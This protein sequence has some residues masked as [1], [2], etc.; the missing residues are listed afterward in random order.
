MEADMGKWNR[1]LAAAVPPG[2]AAPPGAGATLAPKREVQRLGRGES[3]MMVVEPAL[4][5]IAP[6]NTVR[7][8]A[9]HPGHSAGS[10]PAMLPVGTP[11]L[12]GRINEEIAATFH[13]P[14]VCAYQRKIAVGEGEA[15]AANLQRAQAAAHPMRARDRFR[16]VFRGQ[17]G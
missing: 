9:V 17:E 10:I 11:R 13:R 12:R 5:C 16:Q 15:A 7:F 2:A 3:G 6:G 8:R 1:G 14:G 4:L